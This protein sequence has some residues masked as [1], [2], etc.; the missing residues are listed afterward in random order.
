VRSCALGILP[1]AL[2][3]TACGG[4]GTHLDLLSNV[5]VT[6]SPTVAS[7]PAGDT[8][9]FT[10]TV[11]GTAN[12]AV[13]WSVNETPGGDATVGTISSAG[14]Y[15]APP[16]IPSPDTVSV[17]A[18]SIANKQESASAQVTITLPVP[19]LTTL[20]PLTVVRSFAD[21]DLDVYGS[22]FSA[23]SQVVF[24]GVAELTTYLGDDTHLKAHIPAADIATTGSYSVV[25][26][27]NGQTSNSLDFYVVPPIVAQD[28]PVAAQ[29]TTAGVNIAVVP[30]ASPTL[31][32][33]AVGEGNTAGGTGVTLLPGETVELFLAGRGIVGGTYYVIGGELQDIVVTQPLAADFQTAH[34]QDG[35]PIPAVT[36][37]IT[38]LPDAAPGPRNILVI[39]T[40]GEI[41]VFVGGVLV[42]VGP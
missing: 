39:N 12:T 8:Q 36:L 9:Q 3:L 20:T 26:Q 14:L 7:V 42:A 15:T 16:A 24:N 1:A 28:V 32:L 33:L 31:A 35:N 6:I 4:G 19:K 10:A 25:V 11:T 17:K 34:D 38:A 40:D 2:L 23:T 30:L 13:A 41:S 5:R 37:A 27:D 22:R 18:T 29:S 21:F